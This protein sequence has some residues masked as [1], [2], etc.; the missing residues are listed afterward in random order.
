MRARRQVA[1]APELEGLAPGSLRV[2]GLR[3]E[4]WWE[5]ELLMGL[6]AAE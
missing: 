3:V 4:L 6:V 2:D 5:G 1:R